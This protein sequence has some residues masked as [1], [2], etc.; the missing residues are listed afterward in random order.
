MQ[1]GIRPVRNSFRVHVAKCTQRSG[2]CNTTVSTTTRTAT[3]RRS[4]C[5]L[6]ARWS[7]SRRPTWVNTRRVNTAGGTYAGNA[8]TLS[9]LLA[10]SCGTPSYTPARNRLRAW[11]AVV[12]SVRAA[13]LSRMSAV[14][15]ARNRFPVR[16]VVRVFESATRWQ[17]TNASTRASVRMSA[18]CAAPDSALAPC[19][20]RT[21]SDTTRR[22]VSGGTC[23]PR[24][25]KYSCRVAR[26]ASTSWG[27]TRTTQ[28][29]RN[30][31]A[32]SVRCVARWS[33]TPPRCAV[34]CTFTWRRSSSSASSVSRRSGEIPTWSATYD[35]CTATKSCLTLRPSQSHRRTVHMSSVSLCLNKNTLAK[36]LLCSQPICEP[37]D[38]NIEAKV[39][40]GLRF[41]HCEWRDIFKTTVCL[42]FSFSC[43]SYIMRLLV[44]CNLY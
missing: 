7:L 27:T 30:H 15:L 31:D 19:R 2:V 41:F 12:L 20:W 14:T 34:T 28:L 18:P 38:I 33:H 25:G 32:V 39:D 13:L 44:I 40:L 17:S 29:W 24:A 35:R 6:S 1:S 23:V 11:R 37:L 3:E 21:N 42:K 26:Y 16:R 43:Y 4:W 10:P 22:Q 5:V 9:R 36:K 8:A